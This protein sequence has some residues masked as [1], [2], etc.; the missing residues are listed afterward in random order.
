MGNDA[1]RRA[2]LIIASLDR[3]AADA[4]IDRMPDKQARAIRDELIAIHSL[5]ASEQEAEIQAFLASNR[6]EALENITKQPSSPESLQWGA[7][8]AHA[9]PAANSSLHD[10]LQHTDEEIASNVMHE[11]TSVV[12]AIVHALPKDRAAGVLRLLPANL[13]SRVIEQLNLGIC[14]SPSVVDVI[15]D[16]VCDR[17]AELDSSPRLNAGHQDALQAIMNELSPAERRHMIH[18]L[19]RQNPLLA[20]RLRATSSET[21]QDCYC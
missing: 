10:L 5:N 3:N 9:A 13:Q 4:V 8:T 17:Q 1:Y 14:T 11:R 21:S 15:A 16:C 6:S 12:T 19:E 18:D 20:Q 7:S 2:A